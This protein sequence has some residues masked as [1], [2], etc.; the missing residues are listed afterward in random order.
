[1]AGV[2]V[3]G[4]CGRDVMELIKN[5]NY[6][7]PPASRECILYAVYVFAEYKLWPIDLKIKW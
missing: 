5:T 3:H 6:I 2:D 7:L 4:Y 1:M